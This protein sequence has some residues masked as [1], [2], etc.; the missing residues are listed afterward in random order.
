MA[1]VVGLGGVFYK[2]ADQ[3]AVKDWYQRVLG[4]QFSDWGGAKFEHPKAGATLVSLFKPES[5]KFSPSTLP[6]MINLI[7][8]DL[9]GLIAKAAAAGETPL[10]REA[11]DGFGKFAWFVDPAGV[12][13]E[14]WEPA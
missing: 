5:D 7:V 8:D 2:A 9:D 14:L 11:H 1:A 12:K 4:V 13:L 3:A 6:F 10:G